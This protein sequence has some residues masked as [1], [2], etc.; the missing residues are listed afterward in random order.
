[1]LV[2]LNSAAKDTGK[3][4][5]GHHAVFIKIKPEKGELTCMLFGLDRQSK[6]FLV[7]KWRLMKNIH[8]PASSSMTYVANSQNRLFGL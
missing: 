1:M 8:F 7:E 3:W 2:V 5:S 4:E 6:S